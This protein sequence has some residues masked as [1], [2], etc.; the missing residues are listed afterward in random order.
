MYRRRKNSLAGQ[1]IKLSLVFG[2]VF[3]VGRY[4]FDQY[5]SFNPEKILSDSLI[6][7][8]EFSSKPIEVISPLY[9]IKAY[10]IEEK[11]NP[12][13]SMSIMFKGAGYSA[14]DEN[15][16]GISNLVASTL[17]EGTQSLT[18]QS[19]K[20]FLENNAISISFAT[21]KDD[22]LASILT[23][24]QNQEKAYNLFKEM[25]SAPRFEDKDV[26]LA[27]QEIK[28]SFELQ[29]EHPKNLLS[30]EFAKYLYQNHPYGRNPLGNWDNIAKIDKTD[31]Q[32]YV[33]THFSKNNLII[34]VAGDISAED[35]GKLLDKTFGFLPETP[36]INFVRKAKIDFNRAEQNI[37]NNNTGQNISVWA[38]QGVARSHPDFYPLYV[39]NYI[40]GGSGLSS[41]LSKEIR[42]KQGL[43][44]NIY[45][46]MTLNEKSALL[47]G[48]FSTTPEKHNLVWCLVNQEWN[49]FY[50][51]GV[52]DKEVQ[53]AKNYLI[54]SYNL[55]FSSINNLSEILLYMQKE[56]LG[57]DF[58]Q[59]R[60][61]TIE[62]ITPNDVNKAIKKYYKPQ[63]FIAA[64][65]GKLNNKEKQND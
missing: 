65:I 33:Q 20:E 57:I 12:I 52:S 45:T 32:K 58:L 60:N 16:Q 49:K 28:K 25:L 47:Y 36:S 14:D 44:Y 48:G 5:I 1:L 43:T 9:K 54:S 17:S 63:S 7:R 29:K 64:N 11:S 46:Y 51:Q 3:F 6:S 56:E 40:F 2:C 21:T 22:F 62:K 13:I 8:K 55:R 53:M 27:K 34:G 19:L 23:T 42:E 37:S 50:E 26:L 61:K 41:R 24:S 31:L 10:L 38:S 35:L 30:L 39:A 15:L 18:A 59:N 4:I